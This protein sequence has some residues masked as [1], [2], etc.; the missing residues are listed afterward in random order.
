MPYDDLCYGSP[1]MKY[2]PLGLL[3]AAFVLLAATVA[4][5]EPAGYWL[6]VNDAWKGG[7]VHR[8]ECDAAGVKAGG[9]Y[10]CRPVQ[11]RPL[12]PGGT[13]GSWASMQATGDP[14]AKWA[15]NVSECG[16][17]VGVSTLIPDR[18]RVRFLGTPRQQFE[19]TKCLTLRGHRLE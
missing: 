2:R 7:F 12:T 18:G 13:A 14:G 4:A 3:V 1:T 9:Q 17:E 15:K 8:T 11:M 10:E 5:Q 6:Y 16:A 19:F